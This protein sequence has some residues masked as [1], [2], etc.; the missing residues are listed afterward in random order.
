MKVYTGEFRERIEV[1]DS[2]AG[3][4]DL[5]DPTSSE[6]VVFATYA[7]V[8]SLSGREYWEAAALKSEGTLKFFC[9]WDKRLDAFDTKR[10]YVRWRGEPY[11]VQAVENVDMRNETVVI[12]AAR[13]E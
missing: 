10:L 2:N 12:K 8:S 11:D 4:D 13:R 3:V 7:K 6:K 1:V 9:R 5:G